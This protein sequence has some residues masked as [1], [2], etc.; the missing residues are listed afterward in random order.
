MYVARCVCIT[1]VRVV[2]ALCVCVSYV[3][4]FSLDI[5]THTLIETRDTAYS[6]ALGYVR[7]YAVCL[8]YF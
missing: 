6:R 5:H 4:L 2:V 7:E 1:R 8:H 3:W